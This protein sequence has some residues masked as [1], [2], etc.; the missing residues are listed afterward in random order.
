MAICLHSGINSAGVLD[1]PVAHPAIPLL[2]EDGAHVLGT[3]EPYSPRASC[4][5]S[6]CHDYDKITHAYHFEQGRDEARDD[7]GKDHGQPQLFSPGYFGGYNCMGSSN[8]DITAMK[9]NAGI[10]D[11]ADLGTPDLVMRCQRCH[12]GGGWMEKDRDGKRY[13]QVNPDT[14]PNLDGDYYSRGVDASGEATVEQW[15]WQA[16]G[17]VENDCLLCHVKLDDMVTFDAD[18]STE[19]SPFSHAVSVRADLIRSGAFRYGATAMLEFLNLNMSDDSTQ[20]L[21][22]LSFARKDEDDDGVVESSEIA[23]NTDGSPSLTWNPDAFDSQGLVTLPMVRYPGNDSC[24]YCHLT[25]NS[26]RGFYGFGEGAEAVF[27][28]EGLLVRDYQDDVHKGQVWSEAN[29]EQRNIENCNACHSRNYY[30]LSYGYQS[31]LDADH[32]FL[33]GHSD[34]DTGDDR[35]YEPPAKSCLYCHETA[36]TPAIPSGHEDMLSAHRER[37]KLAGDMTGYVEDTLTRIT[38]T[39]LDVLACEACHITDKVA[40]GTPLQIMYRYAA[41]EDGSLRIRPYNA[42]YRSQWMDKRTGYVLNKTERDSVFRMEI[43]E[44]GSRTGLLIDPVSGTTLGQVDVSYS[45]GRWRFAAPAD[46]ATIVAL[47]GAYDSLLSLKGVENPNT[48]QV[49]GASNFYVLSHNTRPAT[50]AVQCEECHEKTSRGA[51]SSLVSESGVLGESN[52]KT[53][54]E[55]PDRRLIDEGIVEM[56]FPS[57]KADA[58]G[59]ITENTADVLYYSAINPSLSRLG[60]AIAPVFAGYLRVVDTTTGLSEVGLG[61]DEVTQLLGMLSA[62]DSIYL[63]APRYGEQMLRET[64]ILAE[65]NNQADAVLPS[66]RFLVRMA[67]HAVIESAMQSASLSLAQ[68]YKLEAKNGDGESVDQFPGTPLFIKL[69]WTGSDLD[70]LTVASSSDGAAWADLQADQIVVAKAATGD[71]DGYVIIRSNHLS[72]YA[73]AQAKPD[74]TNTSESSG[75][76]GGG[77]LW[78]LPLLLAGMGVLRWMPD[79]RS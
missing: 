78:L 11:F 60:T 16:S 72:F 12:S 46:Y 21:P 77:A 35:D 36:Q 1:E 37:W 75:A 22:L 33:K 18:L 74:S 57:M 51:F 45:H 2:T 58:Q 4:G 29:G 41:G 70:A 79:R 71:T 40:R 56:A 34:M 59:V 25:S 53:V 64:A 31:D 15:D 65:K 28:E 38:Q 52:S 39:H 61:N 20:D 69:P 55:I 7:Y 9:V 8:P 30:N 3:G 17:V 66:Y 13:D 76:G 6:G 63:F 19:T 44:D 23:R 32:N 14:V 54:T 68:V 10:E 42:R 67:D 43:A 50:E 62:S 26:R 49:W 27:D 48:V 24:M 73:V 5:G 47:K